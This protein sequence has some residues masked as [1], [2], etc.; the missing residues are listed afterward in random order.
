MGDSGTGPISG[1]ESS[2]RRASVDADGAGEGRDGR[3]FEEQARGD[4]ESCFAG[5]G[6]DLDGED[7]V[8][9][10]FEKIVSSADAVEAQDGG[11]DVGE[12]SFGGG[13]GGLER[14]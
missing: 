7:G 5:A 11:P 10:D 1:A 8:A 3:V 2:G 13:D 6:D 4:G 12:G 14:A 9:A